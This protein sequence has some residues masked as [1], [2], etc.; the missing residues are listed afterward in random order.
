MLKDS[1]PRRCLR[2]RPMFESLES[3]RFLSVT[4]TGDGG[5]TF[6]AA[7]PLGKVSGV[8]TINN[9]LAAGE[10]DDF[11]SFTVR[12]TGNVNLT[13]GG[14]ASNANMCLYDVDG[15]LLSFSGRPHARTESI[16]R[17]LKR[18]TYVVSVDRTRRA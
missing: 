18:G 14:L 9:A 13:L 15:R 5:Q 16:S 4:L 11:F 6:A 8:M 1:S 17:T 2:V 12:S 10:P 7:A 3:R